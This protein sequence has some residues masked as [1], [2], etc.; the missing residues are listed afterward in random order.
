MSDGA[1]VGKAFIEL[2]PELNQSAAKRAEQQIKQHLQ[3][4]AK[5]AD[6]SL[7][8]SQ[9]DLLGGFTE[10]MKTFQEGKT[11]A[12]FEQHRAEMQSFQRLQK[13]REQ[14]IAAEQKDQQRRLNELSSW[15][16]KKQ[17]IEKADAAD[18]LKAAKQAQEDMDKVFKY[19]TMRSLGASPERAAEVAT[20]KTVRPG[21]IQSQ[22]NNLGKAAKRS[23]MEMSKAFDL[24]S[25]TLSQLSTRIGLAS[26]QMQLLGGFATTFLTGPVLLGLG[27]LSQWGYQFAVATDQAT[28]SLKALLPP[29]YNVEGLVQRLQKLAIKSPAFNADDVITYTSKLVGA[30]ME[31]GK[32]EKLMGALS[33]IFATF[34]VTSD[35]ARLAL[36]GIAQV[37]QKGRA[38]SEELS[39]QIGEQIPIWKLLSD[40]MGVSQAELREMVKAGKLSA[41]EFATALIKIGNSS[42]YIEGASNSVETLGG[43]WQ[44]FKEEVRT[45]LGNAFLANKTAIIAAIEGIKPVVMELVGMFVK[46]L[47]TLID[48]LGRL[49]VKFQQLKDWYDKLTPTARENVNQLV[50][51][52]LAVG[53]ATIA[54]GIFGTAISGVLNGLSLA[55]KLIPFL[56]ALLGPLG[57]WVGASSIAFS[58]LATVLSVLYLKSAGVRKAMLQAFN[59]IKDVI[60]DALLPTIDNLIGSVQSLEKTFGFL[61]FKSKDLAQILRL[62]A[63]PIY[64]ISIALN[65][66]IVIIKAVQLAMLILASIAYAVLA[67]ISTLL[68]PIQQIFQ[69]A[70]HIGGEE[71]KRYGDMAEGI[72]NARKKMEGLVDVSGQWKGLTEMNSHATEGFQD[73]LNN[74]DFTTTG[75][76]GA[77]GQWNG[78]V[79]QSIQKQLTLEDAINNARNAMLSQASTAKTLTDA[80]DS[81]NQSLL[82]LKQ[83]IKSNK[84]TLNEHSQAGQANRT[85]LKAA[86]QASYELM[87]QDIR[88]GV[89]MTEAIRR[90]KERT[91]ALKKEFGKSKETQTAAQKLIDT[92]GKVPKDVK[93]LLKL[94]GYTDVAAKMQEILAAQKVAANPGMKYSTALANERKQW[95]MERKNG[96]QGDGFATGGQIRGPG[97]PTGDKIPIWASDLE[98]MIKSSSAQKLGKPVLD[99]I[100]RTGELPTQQFSRGGQI[101]WPM[102]VDVSKTKFPELLG[103]APGS[104]GMGWIKMMEILHQAFPGLQMLSGYRPGAMTSTG[105]RSYHALGRAVDLP[106]RWDVFNWIS[107]N[108]GRG[109][110]ELIYTPAGGRQIKNGMPHTFTG[111]TIQRDHNDHVHWAYDN[112]GMVPP[113]APFINKT[114]ASELMLNSAQGAALEQKISNSDRPVNVTVYVDG[115][116]R[117]AEI[118]FDEK[119]DELIRALG[120]A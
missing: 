36:M 75:L 48:W 10:Q 92:Y 59:F 64:I 79:D 80:S 74:L 56:T 103:G 99:Y 87:L 65:A 70:S 78:I 26:F 8:Q 9:K 46:A 88:S 14:A 45:S 94:M 39:Q 107:K 34:G 102:N 81:Y 3:G 1:Q 101:T 82:A 43:V 5:A 72:E 98:Y 33:N 111:G 115:V 13:Q 54:L 35:G 27:K 25:H 120:G 42:K 29:G 17:S 106:P 118:V 30:G 108:Y 61:G 113:D 24:T 21:E 40:A 52:G 28:A 38:Y 15:Y 68:W 11:K 23:S 117:D 95:Q 110:K 116:R 119:T 58:A 90:H 12:V 96:L 73:K 7:K 109:T 93:T 62:L 60:K 69:I 100:N 19:R 67:T 47:P 51:F 37:Q 83:S 97:G 20:G 4:M 50:L 89:P 63:A 86:A 18:S 71:G 31:I 84:Q 55:T 16:K 85:A 77:F 49:V 66:L 41:D 105:N 76:S 32:T 114:R 112:G 53:P 6:K 44:Q 2:I 22:F 104:G 91:E 57:I